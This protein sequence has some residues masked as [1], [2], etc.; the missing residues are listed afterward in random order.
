LAVALLSTLRRHDECARARRG[1]SVVGH[2]SFLDVRSRVGVGRNGALEGSYSAVAAH[3]G[4]TFRATAS[5]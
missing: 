5:A 4:G 2:R 3:L 1:D